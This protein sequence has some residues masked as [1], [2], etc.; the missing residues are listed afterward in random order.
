MQSV[1]KLLGAAALALSFL[2]V[3]SDAQAITRTFEFKNGASTV[4][5]GSFSYADSATGVLSFSDL[6]SFTLAV[7]V[8][9]TFQNGLPHMFT[10]SLANVLGF[11]STPEPAGRHFGFDTAS[12]MFVSTADAGVPPLPWFGGSAHA[13]MAAFSSS[14]D[15]GFL[16]DWRAPGMDPLTTSGILAMHSPTE[17]D[18]FSG[19]V[20]WN[21]YSISP[22]SEPSSLA[23]AAAGL[24]LIG[25][26]ARKR[27]PT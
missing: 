3:T 19:I 12:H 22:V 13:T 25:F 5:F 15:Q 17:G 4:A 27:R 23:L 7:N 24:A 10:Y 1:A 9:A 20:S 6:T 2:T 26:M 14:P 18:T 21:N 8:P 16:I 11:P